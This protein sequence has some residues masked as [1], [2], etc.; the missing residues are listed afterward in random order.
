MIQNQFYVDR[1]V[2]LYTHLV[3]NLPALLLYP[4]LWLLDTT[5]SSLWLMHSDSLALFLIL[6][7]F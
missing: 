2:A 6:L 7:L 3:P 1:K 5:A 4:S